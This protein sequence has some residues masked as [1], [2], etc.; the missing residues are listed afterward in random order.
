MINFVIILIVQRVHSDCFCGDISGS[1]APPSLDSISHHKLSHISQTIEN[2]IT[3]FNKL[4]LKDPYA[5]V[6]LNLS[7]AENINFQKIGDHFRVTAIHS[8]N[9]LIHFQIVMQSFSA[10]NG[11]HYTLLF[12][13]LPSDESNGNTKSKFL[14]DEYELPI[15]EPGYEILVCR[16]LY[17]AVSA[18]IR[19]HASFR[20]G[21]YLVQYH[22]VDKTK[23]VNCLSRPVTFS[24]I[25]HKDSIAA[26]I[27]KIIESYSKVVNVQNPIRR[28]HPTVTFTYSNAPIQ[29]NIDKELDYLSLKED[30]AD[31]TRQINTLKSSVDSI[32]IAEGGKTNGIIIIQN[33]LLSDLNDNRENVQ[34]GLRLI[35]KESPLL[36]SKSQ[37]VQSLNREEFVGPIQELVDNRMSDSV[38]ATKSERS[39][40]YSIDD[41]SSSQLSF[42]TVFGNLRDEE[43]DID[44]NPDELIKNAEVIA[45]LFNDNSSLR[46][47]NRIV[48]D[49]MSSKPV[50]RSDAD[51]IFDSPHLKMSGDMKS[52]L[53]KIY[54]SETESIKD[55][56]V[57]NEDPFENFVNKLSTNIENMKKPVNEKGELMFARASEAEFDP[58]YAERVVVDKQPFQIPNTFAFEKEVENRST[59]ATDQRFSTIDAHIKNRVISLSGST[60]ITDTLFS[61][62]IAPCD[63]LTHKNSLFLYENLAHEKKV[64]QLKLKRVTKLSKLLKRPKT[65][66]INDI[67]LK[68]IYDSN[69]EDEAMKQAE[70]GAYLVKSINF[71]SK[72]VA[73]SDKK[74]QEL[75]DWIINLT[76]ILTEHGFGD[77][78]APRIIIYSDY[79]IFVKFRGLS[80]DESISR[81]RHLLKKETEKEVE[82]NVEFDGSTELHFLKVEGGKILLSKIA[83]SVEGQVEMDNHIYDILKRAQ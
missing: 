63:K 73:L 38:I 2:T 54:E 53:K 6:I 51:L 47:Q 3:H 46:N 28:N 64:K 74:K 56:F 42:Y 22:P 7:K 32:S 45:T 27:Q 57:L 61:D 65:D 34:S 80:E 50:Q 1:V 4:R 20:I 60:S 59:V 81:L 8:L 25:L 15:H 78:H 39:E 79:S 43:Y 23:P 31:L 83:H 49:Q 70:H 37:S 17:T 82:V 11:N 18:L 14:R 24:D 33:R 16:F 12:S 62:T 19:K 75:E 77:E 10:L 41:D 48:L 52:A 68:V 76:E 5:N 69:I 36:R 21:K 40:S 29:N 9:E 71:F 67:K 35:A 55:K 66:R 72:A 13:E 58:K 30:E 26:D 44:S